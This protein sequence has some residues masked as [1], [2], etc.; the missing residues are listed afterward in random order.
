MTRFHV[1]REAGI[2]ETVS[3]LTI[4]LGVGGLTFYLTRMFLARENLEYHASLP[5]TDPGRR[6]LAG[7][8]AEQ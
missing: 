4:A 6:R 8:K 5:G 1:Q 7:S 2:S 3:A